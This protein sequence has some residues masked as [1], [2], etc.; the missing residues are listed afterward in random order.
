MDRPLGIDGGQTETDLHPKQLKDTQGT[1]DV[2]KASTSLNGGDRA[3]AETQLSRDHLL[4]D[5]SALSFPSDH[6]ADP[7][8]IRRMVAGKVGGSSH[9]GEMISVW[10]VRCAIR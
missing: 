1:A 6:I 10:F 9:I 4:G 3:H 2:G 5:P 7:K 8:T